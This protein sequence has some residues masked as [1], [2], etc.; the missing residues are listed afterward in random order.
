VLG[1]LKKSAAKLP[2]YGEWEVGSGY[3][4]AFAAVRRIR[5]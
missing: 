4:D 2:G 3:A 5:K 1:I